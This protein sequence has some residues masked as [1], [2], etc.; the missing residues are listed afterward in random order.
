M[1][2]FISMSVRSLPATTKKKIDHVWSSTSMRLGN[3]LGPDH[4]G[5]GGGLTVEFRNKRRSRGKRSY[6]RR[7]DEAGGTNIAP[8]AEAPIPEESSDSA[9]SFWAA[10]SQRFLM[11]MANEIDG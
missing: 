7:E 3:E 6:Q 10:T 4:S 2:S 8:K 9:K 5:P 1:V 11:G